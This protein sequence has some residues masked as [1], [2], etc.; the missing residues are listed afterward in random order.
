MPDRSAPEGYDV[1]AL[2]FDLEC[3]A[4][5]CGRIDPQTLRRST[6]PRSKIGGRLLFERDVLLKWVNAHTSHKLAEVA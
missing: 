4:W 6:C 3:A 1:H 2:V 5:F